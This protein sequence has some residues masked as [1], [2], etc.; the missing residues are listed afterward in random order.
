MND[1]LQVLTNLGLVPL[2]WVSASKF[3]EL[4]GIEQRKLNHRRQHWPERS[5]DK[6]KW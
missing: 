3:A 2:D 5:M 6:A 4:V 1:I